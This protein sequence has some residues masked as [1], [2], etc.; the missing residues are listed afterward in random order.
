[1]L[2]LVRQH[3]GSGE[4]RGKGTVMTKNRSGKRTRAH[5]DIQRLK[6]S[7]RKDIIKCAAAFA[8]IVVLLG[9]KLL[10]EL[11]GIIQPGNLAAGAVQMFG[12]IGLAV[13]GGTSS[14]DFVKCGHEI[15]AVQARTGISKQDIADHE[16]E[17]R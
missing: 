7:R 2:P 12:A 10:L 16:R 3:L 1:M 6:A 9:G 14:M 11:N 15:A 8:A 5:E 4:L 13:L 17:L